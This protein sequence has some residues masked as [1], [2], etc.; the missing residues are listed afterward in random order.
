[1]ILLSIKRYVILI[2]ENDIQADTNEEQAEFLDLITK[3]EIQIMK[4]LDFHDLKEY[5]ILLHS[6]FIQKKKEIENVHL[7]F[8]RK[9]AKNIKIENFQELDPPLQ[10][11]LSNLFIYNFV[12]AYCCYKK[13]NAV[14]NQIKDQYSSLMSLEKIYESERKIQILEKFTSLN[15]QE[16]TNSLQ[17]LS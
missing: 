13:E 9:A 4:F 12:T 7:N 8:L 14:L 6:C 3:N 10:D 17:L 15:D 1:M 5:F 2:I 11:S 16:I